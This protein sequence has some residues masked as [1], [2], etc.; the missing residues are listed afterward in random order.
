MRPYS[1]AHLATATI[2]SATTAISLSAQASSI[3]LAISN[4]VI[5]FEWQEDLGSSISGGISFLHADTE[6]HS[7][8]QKTDI[9]SGDVFVNGSEGIIDFR[10]GGKLYYIKGKKVEGHGISIGGDITVNFTEKFYADA[11]AFYAPDIINGGDFDSYIEANTSV[12]FKPSNNAKI[13]VGYKYTA[14]SQEKV[15]D[16]YEPY[17]GIVIG[18]GAQF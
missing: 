4:D 13:Y 1:L 16:D 2:F 17:Q 11:G 6:E 18:F 12:G 15:K 14:A 5:S 7:H 8:S 10:M 9:I 3:D